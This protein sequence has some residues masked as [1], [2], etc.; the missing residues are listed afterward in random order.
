MLS[1]HTVRRGTRPPQHPFA[2]FPSYPNTSLGETGLHLL[3]P[4]PPTW[5]G[6][7]SK[8]RHRRDQGK[9]A[10]S[11]AEPRGPTVFL[12]K[13]SGSHPPLTTEATENQTH[14]A[15]GRLPP[16]G[17]WTP[18]TQV[19]LCHSQAVGRGDQVRRG[20]RANC[21]HS[22]KPRM[23]PARLGRAIGHLPMIGPSHPAFRPQDVPSF[24]AAPTVPPGTQ[25]WALSLHGSR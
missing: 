23:G 25:G 8:R 12:F 16:P 3:A 4:A 13:M 21:S 18:A 11:G 19:R 24:T 2:L 7:T 17:S 20:D 6:L 9:Q 15:V 10:A 1:Q 14:T 22:E 5:G